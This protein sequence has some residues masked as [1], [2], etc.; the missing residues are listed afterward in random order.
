MCGNIVKFPTFVS[1]IFRF[2]LM[3]AKKV[4]GSEA[5]HVERELGVYDKRL[6]NVF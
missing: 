2:L 3:T 6:K 4:L 1:G 5:F